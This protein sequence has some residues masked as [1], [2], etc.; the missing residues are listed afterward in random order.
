VDTSLQA[1]QFLGF[2]TIPQMIKVFSEE[3][4]P[5]WRRLLFCE[6][7]NL[8]LWPCYPLGSIVESAKKLI[9]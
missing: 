2:V 9:G 1:E 8:R 4:D 3:F 7:A 6:G 5:A